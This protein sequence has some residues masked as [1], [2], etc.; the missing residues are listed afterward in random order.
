MVF[1]VWGSAFAQPAAFDVASVKPTQHG[2][3]AEGLSI[4][5]DPDTPSPGTFTVTNNSLD[6]LIRWAY[7]V[8]EYQISGPA[9]LNDDSESFDIEAKMPPATSKA[10]LRLMM[11][12][13][14]EERFKLS[15]H[16]E[17]RGLPIYELLVAK[18]GARLEKPKPDAKR[19]W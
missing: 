5:Y 18:G 17:T 13:L 19:T 14:L 15:L 6:E 10:Q 11:R 16:R 8:K 9:W 12:T 4:S 7:R 3:N 1:R 2:R